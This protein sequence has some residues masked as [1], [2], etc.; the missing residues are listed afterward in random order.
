M[1]PIL[2]YYGSY[3]WDPHLRNQVEKI[4]K[5]QK[6]AARFGISDY[7]FIKGRTDANMKQLGWISLQDQRAK[8]KV[9]NT[10]FTKG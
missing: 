2:E 10:H 8:S 4:E 6:N 5:V 9:T 1:E 3:V 7:I